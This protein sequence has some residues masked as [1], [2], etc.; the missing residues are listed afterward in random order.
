M[1][2]DRI[3]RIGL[4]VLAVPAVL[5]G[6]WAGFSGIGIAIGPTSAPN[7]RMISPSTPPKLS[8]VS[9]MPIDRA[10]NSGRCGR[11]VGRCVAR[12]TPAAPMMPPTKKRAEGGRLRTKASPLD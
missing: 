9:A 6:I 5:I 10:M 8:A 3:T 4:V 11:V 7:H 1:N 2:R 12:T